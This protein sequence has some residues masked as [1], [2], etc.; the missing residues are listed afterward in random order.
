MQERYTF[1]A[2]ALFGLL[3]AAAAAQDQDGYDF[4]K[5]KW[6]M[7][8]AQV[9]A[10]ESTSPIE[11]GPSGQFDLMI[12]YSGNVANLQTLYSYHFIN[13]K[14]VSTFYNFRESYVN[15]N[16]YLEDYLKI[17]EILTRKYG[18]P[19]KDN[20][21]WSNDLYKGDPQNYGTAVSVGHLAF[22]SDWQTPRT[23]IRLTLKGENF[24]TG[25]GVIYVDRKSKALIES[26]K[27][28]S[29]EENF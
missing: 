14:L 17:K 18:P 13:N 5:T 16:M 6:G 28:K 26:S 19:S 24:K 8:P 11:E 3:T 12:I 1:I 15:D 9:K 27:Q 4:R 29:E 22:Q 25:M 20:T 10:S 23:D 7:T 21:V 2:I